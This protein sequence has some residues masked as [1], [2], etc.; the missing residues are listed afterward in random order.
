MTGNIDAWRATAATIFN[1]QPYSI[2]GGPGIRTTVFLIL[3]CCF[4]VAGS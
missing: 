1:I 4:C 2:H 3:Q